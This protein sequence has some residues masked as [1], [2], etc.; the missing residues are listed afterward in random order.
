M[1]LNIH[2]SG[3]LTALAWLVPHETAAIAACSVYTIQPVIFS[4]SFLSVN[5]RGK[6]D[7]CLCAVGSVQTAVKQG[8]KTWR[9]KLSNC[10]VISR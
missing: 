1:F 2:R 3:V 10:V 7:V 5:V 9:M 8:G 6:S 4:L